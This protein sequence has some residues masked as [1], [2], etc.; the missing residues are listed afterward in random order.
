MPAADG[1]ADWNAAVKRAALL[2]F[3][4]LSLAA[5][6][7]APD[8]ITINPNRPSFANPATTTMPGVA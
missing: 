8:E 2:G 3:L 6:D 1:R 7:K 4:S 5:Q